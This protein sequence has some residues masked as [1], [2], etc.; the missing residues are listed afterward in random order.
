MLLQFADKLNDV[1]SSQE[2]V[3]DPRA[4]IGFVR[5]G[6]WPQRQENDR[7][8]ARFGDQNKMRDFRCALDAFM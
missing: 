1:A 4:P 8:G 3:L 6:N 2:Q 7:V 5:G